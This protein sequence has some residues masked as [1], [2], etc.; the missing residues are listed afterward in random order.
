MKHI[1]AGLPYPWY[2]HDGY[3]LDIGKKHPLDIRISTKCPLDVHISVWPCG[4][5]D[6]YWIS[7]TYP[8]IRGDPQEIWISIG[9]PIYIHISMEMHRICGYP[10]VIAWLFVLLGNGLT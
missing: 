4:H 10:Q 1:V 6:I 2:G 9:N 8:Y 3:P 5:V 7:H